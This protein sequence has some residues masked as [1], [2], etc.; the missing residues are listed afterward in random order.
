MTK[1]NETKADIATHWICAIEYGDYTGLDDA[2]ESQVEEWLSD[3]PM[4]IF[5]Y[6]ENSFF[7]RDEISGMMSDC[8]EVTIL[9]PED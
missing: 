7:A 6:G 8:C 3:Y 1:F 5:Q 4:A 9:T 2:E